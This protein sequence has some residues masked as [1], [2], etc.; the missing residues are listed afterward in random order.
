MTVFHVDAKHIDAA[1]A[2]LAGYYYNT[3]E[4]YKP[5]AQVTMNCEALLLRNW[6]VP[7]MPKP[8]RTLLQI[9]DPAPATPAAPADP[10]AAP[11]PAA[12]SA[13]P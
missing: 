8:I 12:A 1:A 4:N 6:T 10:A 13:A 2:Q 5:V 11:A 9:P 7:L 3:P